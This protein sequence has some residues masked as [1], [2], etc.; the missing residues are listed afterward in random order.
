MED[1]ICERVG[2]LGVAEEAPSAQGAGDPEAGVV[3][4]DEGKAAA[5]GPRAVEADAGGGSEGLRRVR[6]VGDEE[7]DGVPEGGRAERVDMGRRVFEVT[8]VDVEVVVSRSEDR[9]PVPGGTEILAVEERRCRL[10]C[11]PDPVQEEGFPARER[12]ARVRRKERSAVPPISLG[13]AWAAPKA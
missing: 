5:V 2:D 6:R 13:S 12:E 7:V 9:G 11:R 3:L 4:G 1:G 8:R 10:G